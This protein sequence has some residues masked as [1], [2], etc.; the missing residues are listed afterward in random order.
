MSA[1]HRGRANERIVRAIA[2][3]LLG[4]ALLFIAEI[5]RGVAIAATDAGIALTRRQ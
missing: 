1:P 5:A 2:R 4:Y 3:M